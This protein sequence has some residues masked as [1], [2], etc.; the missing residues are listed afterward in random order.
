MRNDPK[1]HQTSLEAKRRMNVLAFILAAVTGYLWG[2]I[3]FGKIYVK[4]FTGQDL[5]QIGSGRTGGTNS[6]RA[7]GF[8]VGFITAMSDVAKGALGLLVARWLFGSWVAADWLPWLE[9]TAGVMTVVG[10]NWSVFIGFKG[11][12]GTGPNVGWATAIWWP[13]FPLAFILMMAMIFL[14]GYASVGSMTMGLIIPAMFVWLYINGTVSGSV[15]FIF[16]GVITA[17]IVAFALRNNFV[18]LARGEERIVGLRAKL[19]A[20]REERQRQNADQSINF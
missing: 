9:A 20:R 5:Q 14:V 16:G 15:A 6:M 2:S 19:K 4:L 11:G 8:K 17:L 1:G 7:A 12:A 3:P 13:M 10:H 18:R